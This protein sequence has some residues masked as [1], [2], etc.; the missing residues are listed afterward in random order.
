MG[1]STGSGCC[2]QVELPLAMPTIF[3]SLRV[4]AVS[5]VALTTVGVLV[6]HGGLGNLINQGQDSNFKP[7]V[8]TGSV[9]CVVLA[10]VV[11]LI[12]CV[13]TQ[14]AD[15]PVAAGGRRE[16]NAFIDGIRWLLDPRELAGTRTASPP[17]WSSN[18]G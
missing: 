14:R 9:L 2:W 13:G 15:D 12:S 4:A 3:A 5:T 10:I 1:Y 6:S 7:E 16:M 8:L 18:C 17:G 11:D